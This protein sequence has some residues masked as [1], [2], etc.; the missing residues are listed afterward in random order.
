MT[1]PAPLP[2]FPSAPEEY[3]KQYMESVLQAITLHLRNLNHVGNITAGSLLL[4]SLP[5]SS[6]DL[7]AGTL[8][9]DGGTVKIKT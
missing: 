4:L 7:K 2:Q 3:S 9:N 6:A 1:I 8:W 5:T